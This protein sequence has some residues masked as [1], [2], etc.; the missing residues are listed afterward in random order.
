PMP[1]RETRPGMRRIRAKWRTA[2]QPDLTRGLAERAEDLV[3]DRLL[4]D[5]VEDFR[6]A[7]V[8]R[9]AKRIRRRMRLRL[10]LAQREDRRVPAVRLRP[11]GVAHRQPE[12]IAHVT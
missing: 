7:D 1:E 11:C 2:V 9:A 3:T 8:R 12:I 10:V 5:R 4:R 6:D